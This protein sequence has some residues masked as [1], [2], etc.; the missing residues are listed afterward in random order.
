[1]VGEAQTGEATL[2]RTLADLREK[3]GQI[4]QVKVE[5]SRQYLQKAQDLAAVNS[6]T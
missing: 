3:R 5:T 1:M 2:G 6:K 4:I